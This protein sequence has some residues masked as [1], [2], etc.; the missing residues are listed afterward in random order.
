[1][2][3]DIRARCMRMAF[4]QCEFV[5][6]PS[7]ESSLCTPG[8]IRILATVIKTSVIYKFSPSYSLGT[9]TYAPSDASPMPHSE[10]G[11]REAASQARRRDRRSAPPSASPSP[12]PP[13]STASAS[14][15]GPP[16]PTDQSLGD[17]SAQAGSTCFQLVP[18][19]QSQRCFWARKSG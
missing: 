8:K 1:M 5:G 3:T 19:G 12:P 6:G 2:T 10:P 17:S 14:E 15:T 13:T 7:G 11:M 4:P 18:I 16:V 9:R